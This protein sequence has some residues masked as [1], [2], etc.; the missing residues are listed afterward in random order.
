MAD[1][2]LIRMLG[3]TNA[4]QYEATD[5]ELEAPVEFDPRETAEAN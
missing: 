2:D 4:K 3:D 1:Y 5:E